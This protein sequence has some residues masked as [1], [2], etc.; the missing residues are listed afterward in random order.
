[1]IVN[2]SSDTSLRFLFEDADIRGELVSLGESLREIYGAH[3][4]SQS[5]RDLLGQFAAA[6]VLISNNL[7][8]RG[9]I[10]LQGRSEGPISL[11]MVECTS[12][13][14][15]RGIARGD[16]G[17]ESASPIT[18]IEG[19]QLAI[20]IEREGGPRYQGIVA[21]DGGSLALALDNYFLQSEQLNTRFWL[22][23]EDQQAAGMVLQQLPAQ[24]QQGAEEREKQWENAVILADTITREE[25]L[26]LGPV[27]ILHRL[28]NEENVR[29]FEPEPV[30]F[31]CSCSRERS[32][33]AL[34]SLP[35]AELEEILAEQG[36]IDMTCE[37]CG[38]PY[39][40]ARGD[41]PVLAEPPLLH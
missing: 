22:S 30:V 14:E 16:I 10:I 7:K 29:L 36:A 2:P 1:M 12:E 8:Y 32:L 33:A 4:Y 21:L 9:K 31:H 19:G 20:T 18:L 37:M 25:L 23:T 17:Y 34:N 3:P 26:Q 28:Y 41:L 5:A 6:A 13:S 39:K 35:V 11:I 40:F 24:L 27:E 15:I 38:T